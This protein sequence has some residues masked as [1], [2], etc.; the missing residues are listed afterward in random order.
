MTALTIYLGSYCAEKIAR[1]MR[2]QEEN[3]IACSTVLARIIP[4]TGTQ[5]T[6]WDWAWAPPKCAPICKAITQSS[7]SKTL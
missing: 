2:T 7:C 1:V 6:N 5:A 4:E 3:L